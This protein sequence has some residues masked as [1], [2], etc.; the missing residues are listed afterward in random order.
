[1]RI[2]GWG[3]SVSLY[4]QCHGTYDYPDKED[5]ILALHDA[6]AARSG[7]GVCIDFAE[8]QYLDAKNFDHLV[9]HRPGERR[10]KISPPDAE[11]RPP[12]VR[13]GGPRL[14]EDTVAMF[15]LRRDEAERDALMEQEAARL[16]KE[17]NGSVDAADAAV[18][19]RAATLLMARRQGAIL[20]ILRRWREAQDLLSDARALDSYSWKARSYYAYAIEAQRTNASD[21]ATW[22]PERSLGHLHN[23]RSWQAEE[24]GMID[25]FWHQAAGLCCKG[26]PR[27]AHW[28]MHD[29][30]M[31]T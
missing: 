27:W 6:K 7:E 2:R 4:R 20:P 8:P 30:C 3:W 10:P 29:G 13:R 11:P 1:M 24:L 14:L 26:Q 25:H 9:F 21:K 15:D 17:T 5:G 31:G 16:M 18:M 22:V 12:P 23:T 19:V 28:A